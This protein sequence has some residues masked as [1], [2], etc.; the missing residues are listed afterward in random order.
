MKP[1]EV[2]A[3]LP[4]WANAT[5]ATL[6]ASP[7]WAMPCRLGDTPCTMRLDAPVPAD[8]LRISLRFGDAPH[9]LALADTPNHPELHALWATRADV[10]ESILL[11]LAERECG[12]LFQLLENSMRR[13]LR[14]EGLVPDDAPAD[15]AFLSARL[16]GENGA[17]RLSFALTRTPTV[18]AAWG[19]LRFI[20][21]DHPAVRDAV[22]PAETE[23]AAFSLAPADLASLAPGDALLLPELDP[24][25]TDP[26][27]GPAATSPTLVV[28]RRFAVASAVVPWTDA[29]LLRVLADRPAADPA[30]SVT[31]GTLLDDAART[32]PP[33]PQPM[34][35][36]GLPLRL[37]RGN[38]T[39]AS[40]RL[41][42]LGATFAFM[43][44]SVDPTAATA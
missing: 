4:A 35:P 39:I 29:N 21:A 20:Q 40:G 42:R 30:T 13:Q 14:V 9:T 5:P 17:E 7:A 12:P 41:E 24:A 1:F 34:P 26:A 36:E 16:L 3:A 2:L 19:Q 43:A 23:Y 27:T 33:A 37:V 10:P 22:L 31:V 32:E 44:E 11:A 8:T 25:V 28:D 15:S 6:L 38:R 18:E